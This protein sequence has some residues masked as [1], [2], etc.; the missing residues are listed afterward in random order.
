MAHSTDIAR[1]TNPLLELHE[2][3]QSVWLDHISRPLITGGE[4]QRRVERDGV[5]GVTSNPTI[6]AKALAESSDYDEAVK[7][8]VRDRAVSDTVL[9]ERLMIEDIQMAADVLRPVFDRTQGGDGF[10]S[11]EVSP[12]CAG[13]TAATIA[14]ARRLWFEVARLNCMIKVPATGAG[15]PAI[16][17]LLA[18]GININ[19][20]L[21]FSL[22]HYEAVA[23]A[24]LHGV[25]SHHGRQ[26]VASVASIFV[27]RLDAAVDPLLDAIGSPEA[28]R[29]RGRVALA[30]ARR[31]YRRF[32]AIFHGEPFVDPR[33]RGAR[34]Q[35]PLWASTGTKDPAY[36]DVRYLEGLV[37]PE[38]VTTVPPA[39]LEAFRDHGAVPP[40][41]LPSSA[42][43]DDATLNG[44]AALGLDLSAITEQ[45]QSDGVA[46]FARSYQQ[47]LEA[48]ADKRRTTAG[49]GG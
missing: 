45:L 27:S 35:R 12:A 24:Y 20:T 33:R 10:V 9:A 49:A 42:D 40:G 1:R 18:Q 30:N 4:L 48:V 47:L 31:I 16:E 44:A 8:I 34:I 38:T 11:L 46:A 37:A 5:T 41:G 19:I 3:G 22:D 39:T 21:M 23:R 2:R 13:D 17:V 26:H 36:S 29:L 6:F 25:R 14:E 32:T 28:N 7:R 15:I 43:E